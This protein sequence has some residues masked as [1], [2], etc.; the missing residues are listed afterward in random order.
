MDDMINVLS[1]C[2]S[3]SSSSAVGQY[4]P[5]GGVFR[6]TNINIINYD[7]ELFAGM[8]KYEATSARAISFNISIFMNY[9]GITQIDV[10]FLGMAGSSPLWHGPEHRRTRLSG[11]WIGMELVTAGIVFSLVTARNHQW[12]FGW[13]WGWNVAE[14]KTVSTAVQME[15]ILNAVM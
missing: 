4:L 10:N 3:L 1:T 8:W 15:E 9:C 7:T 14:K 11:K 6:K 13:T 5:M 2:Y 12:Y